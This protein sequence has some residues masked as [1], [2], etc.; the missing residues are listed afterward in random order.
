[1]REGTLS[2]EIM[3]HML[4]GWHL[5]NRTASISQILGNVGVQCIL[6]R[7]CSSLMIGASVRKRIYT[8]A[9]S[10]NAEIKKAIGREISSETRRCYRGGTSECN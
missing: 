5:Q 8:D 6:E 7:G 2:S 3:F 10:L 9:F 4:G 1:M